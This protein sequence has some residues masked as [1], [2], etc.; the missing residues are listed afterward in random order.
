MGKQ[1]RIRKLTWKYFLKQKAR[2]LLDIVFIGVLLIVAPLGTGFLTLGL[3]FKETEMPNSILGS[4]SV[5]YFIGVLTL[6]F[7]FLISLLLY[8][9]FVE[10]II[11]WIKS[12]WRRAK[13][14]AQKEVKKNG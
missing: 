8:V 6:L 9:A 14:R 5:T 4:L 1:E 12:N 10:Y 11:E 7:L 2:E 13:R 3:F